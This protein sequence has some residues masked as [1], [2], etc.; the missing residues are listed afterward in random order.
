[1]LFVSFIASQRASAPL[2]ER[3]ILEKPF[4]SFLDAQK[5]VAASAT[6]LYRRRRTF[7]SPFSLLIIPEL[8]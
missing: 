5:S 3:Q 8:V 1:V 6:T 7:V 2:L 4:R